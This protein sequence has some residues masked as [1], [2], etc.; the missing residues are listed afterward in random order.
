MGEEDAYAKDSRLRGA[1]AARDGEDYR[2]EK[3]A[4]RSD[5]CLLYTS[6]NYLSEKYMEDADRWGEMKESVWE[7]YTDFMVEYGVIEEAVPT[8]ICFT[9]EFL[10]E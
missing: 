8:D 1:S 7:N 4:D 5:T 10:P 3:E 2:G 9:N 6:Q